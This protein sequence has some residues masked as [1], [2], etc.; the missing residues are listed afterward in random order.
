M[1]ARTE[2]VRAR[3]ETVRGPCLLGTARRRNAEYKPEPTDEYHHFLRVSKDTV[4]ATYVPY[5]L[6][7]KRGNRT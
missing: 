3:T 5:G 1:R 7:I 2:T 6:R 4:R